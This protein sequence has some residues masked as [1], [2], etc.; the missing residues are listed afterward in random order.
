MLCLFIKVGESKKCA[1]NTKTHEKTQTQ[2]GI[3]VVC[4]I[5]HII[6]KNTATESFPPILLAIELY[7]NLSPLQ[8]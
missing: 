7:P 1:H 5:L 8:L 3:L 6:I 4:S 2:I